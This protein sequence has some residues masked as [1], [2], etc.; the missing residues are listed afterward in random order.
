LILE[1]LLFDGLAVC[2]ARFVLLLLLEELFSVLN[3]DIVEVF[4]MEGLLSVGE[5]CEPIEIVLTL[6]EVIQNVVQIF[7]LFHG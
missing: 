2:T 1:L 7:R 5:S 4:T 3:D 6:A